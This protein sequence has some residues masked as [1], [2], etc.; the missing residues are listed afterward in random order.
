MRR[1]SQNETEELQ[2]FESPSGYFSEVISEA[3]SKRKL[4]ASE[5]VQNYL[6]NLLSIYLSSSALNTN[7]TLAEMYLKAINEDKTN[8]R[9]EK[10]RK[11]GDQT[12]YVSGF[13]G[14]SLKRKLVDIDYYADIGGLAYGSLAESVTADRDADVFRDFSKRFLDFVDVLTYISQSSLIQTNQDLLRLYERY[15]STG[16]EL[17]KDQLVEKGILTTVDPKKVAQ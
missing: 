11:L 2:L 9:L 1:K 7:E 5:G 14:D 6:V 4:E 15:V 17:A 10:L 16:S 12:L 8:V 3:F 13:F